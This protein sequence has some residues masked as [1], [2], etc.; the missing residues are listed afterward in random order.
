MYASGL[1]QVPRTPSRG[2]ERSR[3]RKG[4]SESELAM[5]AVPGSGVALARRPLQA[6]PVHDRDSSATVLDEAGFLQNPRGYGDTGSTDTEHLGEELLR[7]RKLPAPDAVVRREQPACAPLLHRVT[8]IAG[9][10]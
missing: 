4:S 2:R 9:H 6:T 8:A 3:R 7:Q 1:C 10:R 5:V